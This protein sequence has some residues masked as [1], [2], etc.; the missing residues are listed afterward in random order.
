[1]LN[2]LLC[3]ELL[4]EILGRLQEMSYCKDVCLVCRRWLVVQRRVKTSLGLLVPESTSI[5]CFGSS[6]RI[7]LRQYPQI[8]R[9]S[10]ASGQ[11]QMDTELLDYILDAIGEGCKFLKELRFGVGPVTCYGLKALAKGSVNLTSLE[12]VGLSPR[13]FPSLTEFKSLRELSLVLSG[14]NS[15]EDFYG[16]PD[17]PLSLERLCLVGIGVGY[18]GLGWIWR[19]CPKL[20][21]LEFYSCEGFGDSD[22]SSFVKALSSLQ[23]LHLRRC[24]TIA[25]DILMLAAQHCQT[26]GTLVFYDGGD[27]EG[28]HAVVQQCQS[29]EVLDLR[30]PLDLSNEDLAIIAEN[31]QSLKSLRLHSCWLATGVGMKLLGANMRLSLEELVLVRCR[32]VV[33]EPGIL[34]TLGQQLKWLKK[35]DLSD[36]DCLCD[37]ELGAML[38]SCKSLTS[39]RLWRCRG[40]TDMVVAS[41]IQNCHVLETIDI[42]ICDGITTEAVFALVLGSPKLRQLGVEEHKISKVT[43]KLAS[44]K[45][46]VIVKSESEDFI[47]KF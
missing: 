16:I 1:M 29:L 47:F 28:L 45:K 38:A 18:R 13:F 46:I 44:K 34:T 15:I 41:V 43:R 5:S 7:L 12:L 30:L 23:E 6:V 19:N 4:G 31:C 40:L 27:T 25:N 32:A 8:L 36:N 14:W 2:N 22:S 33:Q 26:L 21:K 42:M 17:M 39:L 9:L 11:L 35:L 10:V 3:D 24:R 37:K 20:R